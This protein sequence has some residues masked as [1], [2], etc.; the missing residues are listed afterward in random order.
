MTNT[1]FLMKLILDTK[2]GG[3]NEKDNTVINIISCFYASSFS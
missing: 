1:V 3:Q 2:K